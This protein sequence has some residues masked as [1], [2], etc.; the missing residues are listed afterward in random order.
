VETLTMFTYALDEE[1]TLELQ[2]PYQAEA[3]YQ[4][5]EQNRAFLQRYLSWVGR[6]HSRA[7]M[8]RFMQR[9]LHGMAEERRWAWL[10]RVRGQA[11][12][13]VG[14]WI[15]KPATGECEVNYWLAQPFT[16]R[17]VLT[18][19]AR[20]VIQYAFSELGIHHM[21]IGFQSDNSASTGV[22]RRLGFQHEVTLRANDP[23][24]DGSYS[25]ISMYGMLRENW[26]TGETPVFALDQ[27]SGAH[28][29]L[30]EPRHAAQ[31]YAL[32]EANMTDLRRW[33][34]AMQR[35]HPVERERSY[36]YRMLSAYADGRAVLAGIYEG[37]QVRGA[38]SLTIKPNSHSGQ[39]GY[40]LDR[41]AR[42]R[43]LMSR[44]ARTLT[45][46]GFGVYGLQRVYLRAARDNLP[47]RAVAERLGMQQEAILR[48]EAF[49]DGR[50]VDHVVYSILADEW[51]AQVNR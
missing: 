45:A 13:R 32:I 12:G 50:Y 21:L 35:P 8:L 17:G 3:L 49:L 23:N 27:G 22:A 25:T 33:F 20:A 30:L 10:I 2:A 15:T 47:S 46:I 41:S 14:L 29:R 51:K 5:V 9:D 34:I 44:A 48:E 31:Q 43:G 24:G 38:I 16:G 28:L 18:R 39:L 26:Q 1:I 11:A 42:G 7:D 37:D 19:A 6:I 40:W 36:I 4:L